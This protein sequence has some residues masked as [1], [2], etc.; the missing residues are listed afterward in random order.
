MASSTSTQ[1]QPPPN[2]W[3]QFDHENQYLYALTTEDDVGKHFFNLVAVDS[4]GAHVTEKLEVHVRQHKNTRAFTHLFTLSNVSW[5]PFQF[6]LLI[7]ATS[8]L[9]KRVTTRIFGD[10]NIQTIAVQK[11][12]RNEKDSTWYENHFV[13][14]QFYFIDLF[15][16][17]Q[18]HGLMTLCQL[19]R[20]QEI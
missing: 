15:I 4:S 16:L 13:L 20:V 8:S 19:I 14:T 2:Y 9:L 6:A 10:S 17:G 11:I 5:D 12:T 3:I 7:E 18:F 1:E